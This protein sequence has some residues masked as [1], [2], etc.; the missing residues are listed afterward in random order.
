MSYLMQKFFP[1]MLLNMGADG[2]FASYAVASLFGF[3]FLY[4]L[5]PETTGKTIEE[6]EQQ[7][8]DK[9]D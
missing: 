3:M 6:I 7:L 1:W 2:L 8:V 9:K 4:K 5:L